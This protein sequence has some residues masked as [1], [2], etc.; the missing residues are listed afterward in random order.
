MISFR[1]NVLKGSLSFVISDHICPCSAVSHNPE[2]W[3]GIALNITRQKKYVLSI[4]SEGSIRKVGKADT[5]NIT[6]K[7][8]YQNGNVTFSALID[9][10]SE[11]SACGAPIPAPL[12]SRAF[13]SFVATSETEIGD[14]ELYHVIA[15]IPEEFD[16]SQVQEHDE[17]GRSQIREM[18]KRVCAMRPEMP[19]TERIVS[20]ME[21]VAFDLARGQKANASAEIRALFVEVR[22]RLNRSLSGK[23]LQELIHSAFT[24]KLMKAEKKMEK[25]RESFAAIGQ[26][27]E[28]LT[29]AVDEKLKWM[30]GY[31]V[32]VTEEAKKAAV[33]TLNTFLLIAENNTELP[34]EAKQRAKDVRAAAAPVL[35]YVIAMM[36]FVCY[37]AFFF[38]RRKRTQG[39]KKFD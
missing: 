36:E 35:L 27:L 22:N 17:E 14:S 15:K 5:D 9:S 7:A 6:I 4:R 11:Y 32:D 21:G 34:R 20:E 24:L 31:V 12:L 37:L 23:E 8:V 2:S 28:G 18:E 16:R 1:V 10:E 3:I 19:L 25:R 13:F 26:E 39:F 38:I 33:E 30:S 29:R